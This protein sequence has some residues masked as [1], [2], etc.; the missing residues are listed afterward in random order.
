MAVAIRERA[1]ELG[2][3]G[4]SRERKNTSP[5]SE[6]MRTWLAWYESLS[7]EDREQQMG[8][9]KVGLYDVL[10]RQ[11]F[12]ELPD[13]YLRKKKEQAEGI[14]RQYDPVVDV[15][16]GILH[17]LSTQHLTKA[18][19]ANAFARY[20]S[21]KT[22]DIQTRLREYYHVIESTAT[23]EI[24]EDGIY[25]PALST[26]RTVDDLYE[27]GVRH[28]ENCH[29]TE[30]LRERAEVVGIRKK[31]AILKDAPVGTMIL[32]V[33]PPSI[34][35]VIKLPAEEAGK[36]GNQE[37]L[38]Q[39]K[40]TYNLNF[41]DIEQV[42][43]NSQGKREIKFTR[44]AMQGNYDE[45]HHVLSKLCPGYTTQDRDLSLSGEPEWVISADDIPLDAH[46]LS[47]FV[48]VNGTTPEE[49]LKKYFIL[50]PKAMKEE[51]FLPLY[52][53]VISSGVQGEYLEKLMSTAHSAIDGDEIV[54]SDIF[55]L[56]NAILIVA[57]E[58]RDSRI[59]DKYMLN[60]SNGEKNYRRGA[61]FIAMGY[62]RTVETHQTGC[63]ASGT[64]NLSKLGEEYGVEKLK[65]STV[66]GMSKSKKEVDIYTDGVCPCDPEL[67]HFHCTGCSQKIPVG[68]GYETCPG[69]G[70]GK[71]C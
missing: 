27:D 39:E 52:G 24:R 43:E 46:M 19:K 3:G 36:K 53:A 32:S 29:T 34:H 57:E 40:G 7:H 16:G 35:R 69:C 58:E 42:V 56:N 9:L 12:R 65:N 30:G 63:G 18:E 1:L 47:S 22:W 10:D 49:L 68:R 67:T 8:L 11:L 13:F 44:Y 38:Q 2:I 55:A 5:F 66:L 50:D 26:T 31:H 60:N 51:D 33:S 4:A 21:Y 6:D 54:I 45:Y 64:D 20:N 59:N 48:V 62:T 17:L 23:L 37:R 25:Q 41:V 61:N 15:L 14:K 71:T 28:A 70:M